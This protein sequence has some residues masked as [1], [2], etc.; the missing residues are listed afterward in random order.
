[1]RR[2]G[3]NGTTSDRRFWKGPRNHVD[4]Y[5]GKSRLSDARFG[6]TI[7]IIFSRRKIHGFEIL[8]QLS[9]Y[10]LLLMGKLVLCPYF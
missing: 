6:K 1:M 5:S 10:I 7:L 8:S 9:L 4:D 3:F 2:G